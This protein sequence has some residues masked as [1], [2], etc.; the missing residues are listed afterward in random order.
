M[1]YSFDMVRLEMDIGKLHRN[2]SKINTM[3]GINRN[4]ETKRK[5]QFSNL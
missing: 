5:L 2:M 1:V 3:E 4:N